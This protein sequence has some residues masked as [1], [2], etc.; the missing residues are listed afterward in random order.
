MRDLVRILLLASLWGSSYGLNDQ[1]PITALR[2]QPLIGFGTWNLKISPSNTSDA[3]SLAIQVGYRQIDCAAAYSNEKDVGKGIAHGLTKANLRRDEIWVTSKLWNDH[4]A[5][6]KVEEGLNKTLDDLGLDY[7][8]LY[9]MHW[10]VGN[11]P[12]TSKLHFDYVETWHAMET[13]LATG[14]VRNIGVCN[15]SPDQLKR[16]IRF[17]SVKPAVHQMELH[18]Y[19]QQDKWVKAH[20]VH[21][22]AVTAYSPLGNMNPIYW[23]DEDPPL[24]LKNSIIVDIASKRNCTA[25]QVVLAWG[26]SRGTSVIPKSSHESRIV[27]NFGSK[28]CLLQGD[29]FIRIEE[30]GKKHLTRFNN[31]S[32]G[33][34]VHLFEGLDDS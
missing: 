26:M 7:L 14:R 4:H 23:G 24:L 16:L 18:P 17:S 8:D 5:P 30:L 10:P 31:P 9:L 32:S 20:Q 33:W 25:A 21:G 11:T 22:I 13:L 1:Q 6:W 3:V 28:E 34:G 15:F 19:L 27:E 2:G 29:D 12:G